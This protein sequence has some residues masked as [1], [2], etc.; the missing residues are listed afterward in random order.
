MPSFST[1]S[2][3]LAEP[4]FMDTFKRCWLNWS[5]KKSEN[6]KAGENG[7]GQHQP[8]SNS[9]LRRSSPERQDI[10]SVWRSSDDR[11]IAV[12]PIVALH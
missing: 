9:T 2:C 12:F 5:P 8:A 7:T 1:D 6:F 3:L 10:A 4:S 11:R